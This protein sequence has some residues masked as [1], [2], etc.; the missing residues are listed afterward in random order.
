MGWPRMVNLDL[1]NLFWKRAETDKAFSSY[2]PTIRALRPFALDDEL[3]GIVSKLANTNQKTLRSYLHSA[4]LPY[5]TMWLE[6]DFEQAFQHIERPAQ[7]RLHQETPKRVGWV[8]TQAPMETIAITR[9]AALDTDNVG[10]PS[11]NPAWLQAASKAAM[12]PVTT[13]F[14]NTRRFDMEGAFDTMRGKVH[15]DV[16][17][18]IRDF[19]SDP[20]QPMQSWGVFP[21]FADKPLTRTNISLLEPRMIQHCVNPVTPIEGSTIYERAYLMLQAGAADQMGELGFICAALALLNEVPVKFVPFRPSG[22]LRAGGRLRPYMSSSIVSIE[23]PATRRRL[24]EIEKHLKGR[25]DAAKKARHE[26]RGHWRHVDKLPL[27]D[28]NHHRWERFE[29]R[30]GRLRWRMWIDHHE[31]GDASIGWVRQSYHATKARGRIP[32]AEEAGASM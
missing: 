30:D 6:V 15:D 2:A 3:A 31:R 25:G 13:L 10:T 27:C 20:D 21:E 23:V 11:T 7:W 1:L 5:P 18:A 4:R 14:T 32:G 17:D 22:S 8:L 26:V 12:Y 19:N 28:D 16:L 9:I 29:D 24:K